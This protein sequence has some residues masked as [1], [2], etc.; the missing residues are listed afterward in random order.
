MY[1]KVSAQSRETQKTLKTSVDA[2]SRSF[3]ELHSGLR[4]EREQ[5]TVAMEQLSQ[6]LMLKVR[7]EER[8]KREREREIRI[9]APVIPERRRAIMGGETSGR[10]RRA[11]RDCIEREMDAL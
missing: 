11:K 5:R 8:T 4:E 7:P 3:G 6:R 1:E 9:D 10:T 2:L